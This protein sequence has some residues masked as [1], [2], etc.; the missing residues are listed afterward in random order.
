MNLR[1]P[2]SWCAF[3][4]HHL[5]CLI[6]GAKHSESFLPQNGKAQF[7]TSNNNNNNNNNGRF[8]QDHRGNKNNRYTYANTIYS[9]YV[10]TN[11]YYQYGLKNIVS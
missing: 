11:S 1:Y 2:R 9:N 5:T 6:S 4:K 7:N 10:I 3:P 8:H